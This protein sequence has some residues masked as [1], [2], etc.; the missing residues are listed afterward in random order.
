MNTKRVCL[1]LAI[2]SWLTLFGAWPFT[3]LAQE[4]FM[5]DVVWTLSALVRLL[6]LIFVTTVIFVTFRGLR[7]AVRNS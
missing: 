7:D 3:I 5:G 2:G 1:I 6:G 4:G